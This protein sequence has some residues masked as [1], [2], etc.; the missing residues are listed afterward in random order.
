[1][2]TTLGAQISWTGKPGDAYSQFSDITGDLTAVDVQRGRST[3]LDDIQTGTATLTLDNADGK[4]T[5]GRAYGAEMLPD[6]VRKVQST[7]GFVAG[8]GVTLATTNTQTFQD[9]Q[10][11]SAAV[12]SSTAG[13]RLVMTPGVAVVPGTSYR[14]GVMARTGTGT[15]QA[16]LRIRY[17]DKNGVDLGYGSDTGP[18][19]RQYPDVVTA[20]IPAAYYRL[21]DSALTTSAAP[22]VGAN[23]M[24]CYNVAASSGAMWSGDTGSTALFNGTSSIAEPCGLP[25]S[26]SEASTVEFWFQPTAAGAVLSAA[27]TKQANSA[28]I[29]P[30]G[31][32]SASGDLWPSLY[33]G[34]DGYL[35]FQATTLATA[36]GRSAYSVLDGYWHH[37]V[38]TSSAEGAFYYVDGS[39]VGSDTGTG[40]LGRPVLGYGDLTTV[41]AITG[42]AAFSVK[43]S[44]SWLAGRVADFAVYAHQLNNQQVNDHFRHGIG[45]GRLLL[46]SGGVGFGPWNPTTASSVAPAN[47]ATAAL[48]L[49]DLGTGSATVYMDQ[50]SLRV[51]SPLY[52]RVRPRRRV[53]VFS[54]T[55]QNL[56][57]LGVGLGYQLGPTASYPGVDTIETGGWV[58]GPNVNASM[59]SG[60]LQFGTTSTTSYSGTA[61]GPSS[62]T[63]TATPWMLVPG[64]SYVF[65][66]W[67][68][69]TTFSPGHTS[70]S[71]GV[72]VT[73]RDVATGSYF[74]DSTPT[75]TLN[76][77]WQ[78]LTYTWTMAAS[79]I[80]PQ[81]E[82]SIFS[83]ETATG[84][85]S[86]VTSVWGVQVI[87]ITNGATIPAYQFG[88]GTMPVFRGYVDKWEA[89]TNYESDAEVVVSCTDAYR[90]M[91]EASL[92]HAPVALGFRPDWACIGAWQIDVTQANLASVSPNTL[93]GGVTQTAN[94]NAAVSL[95]TYDPAS[96]STALPGEY[97]GPSN[98]GL[99]WQTSMWLYLSS[100]GKLAAGASFEAWYEPRT[101]TNTVGYLTGDQV[102]VCQ[103]P[104]ASFFAS[105]SG[106]PHTFSCGWNKRNGTTAN[107]TAGSATDMLKGGHIALEVNTSGGS[108][109]TVTVKMFYNG[110]LMITSAAETF[111][112]PTTQF[113]VSGGSFVDGAST[114]PAFNGN[115][116]SPAMY[117]ATGL[118]WAGRLAVF[119]SGYVS[120]NYSTSS[121]VNGPHADVVIPWLAAAAGLTKPTVVGSVGTSTNLVDP[122]GF[123]S[124]TALDG[125]S[126]AAQQSGGLALMSRYGPVM[127]Q[128]S[129]YRASGNIVFQFPASGPT[130]PTNALLWVSDIDRT[131]TA[132]QPTQS[133]KTSTVTSYPA[134]SQ[135]GTHIEALEIRYADLNQ[136][137]RPT[138]FLTSYIAP[139][140]RC[141]LISFSVIN[142]ALAALVPVVD[143]GTHVALTDLPSTSPSDIYYAWVESVAVSAKAQGG[144]LAPDVTFSLSPDFTYVPIQ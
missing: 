133:G 6:A 77:G 93:L 25:C 10:S 8:P 58:L 54:T 35:Y 81:F 120:G 124:G 141:D 94:A 46:S 49:L 52:G 139:A 132:V 129:A 86:W 5:P 130:G 59:S 22:T 76:S 127:L 90:Q 113:R 16:Q 24:V 80:S 111:A 18:G 53:R 30:T 137:A 61:A 47:A 74:S 26:G 78:Q 101:S 134:V 125:V 142:Q 64:R 71:A 9:P 140:V 51:L 69:G 36:Q 79:Y 97:L 57:P 19:W 11:L 100:F 27:N 122:P 28:A 143:V 103:G 118:D 131:W 31:V 39:L 138:D 43:P 123:T 98:A 56:V 23:A 68:Q 99:K 12:T 55:G 50:F 87:D 115:V 72:N 70:T 32:P 44:S 85:A 128:D 88:D 102:F 21:N 3:E 42:G 17:A 65:S 109:P 1:M 95:M 108:A 4:Y 91:G 41:T 144:V 105:A 104:I 107:I 34:T 62:A 40:V 33:V 2:S 136:Q 106:G 96:P 112:A 63:N 82:F 84:A 29:S 15:A 121:V 116:Y 114:L 60:I 20:S 126:L 92:P 13:Q 135:Y 83:N 48:E 75:I 38:I 73:F 7:T 45:G 119:T 37:V 117:G 67:L 89:T 66:V 110:T 14:G